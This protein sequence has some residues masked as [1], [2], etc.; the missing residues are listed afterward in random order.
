MGFF[1]CLGRTW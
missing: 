1:S